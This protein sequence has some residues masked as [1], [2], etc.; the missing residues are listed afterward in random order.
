MPGSSAVARSAENA[1][2]GA[3]AGRAA[4]VRSDSAAAP[5]TRASTISTTRAATRCRAEP[6][7]LV[8]SGAGPAISGP[9]S[10]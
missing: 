1:S 6:P 10:S 8:G 3:E 9:A 4:G 5:P 7:V 2:G